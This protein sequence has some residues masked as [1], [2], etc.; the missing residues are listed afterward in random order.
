MKRNALVVCFVSLLLLSGCEKIMTTS[1]LSDA[2]F[3]HLGFSGDTLKVI[4]EPVNSA[5]SYS[6]T[7]LQKRSPDADT[8]L[9]VYS[10]ILTTSATITPIRNPGKYGVLLEAFSDDANIAPSGKDTI[11]TKN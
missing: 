3:S 9:Y 5:K 2:K 8:I 4:W 1:I 11:L 6:I 10:N 7:V